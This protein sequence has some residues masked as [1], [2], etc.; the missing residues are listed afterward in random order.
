[1]P[2]GELNP[3]ADTREAPPWHRWL[4]GL[5]PA[6]GYCHPKMWARLAIC[7]CNLEPVRGAG[8]GHKGHPGQGQGED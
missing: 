5:S 2:W 8:L 6:C 7:W 3:G 1:M 4:P